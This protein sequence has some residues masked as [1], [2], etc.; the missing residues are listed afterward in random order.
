MAFGRKE[1]KAVPEITGN[2]VT[3]FAMAAQAPSAPVVTNGNGHALKVLSARECVIGVVTQ[4]QQW[5]PMDNGMKGVNLIVAGGLKIAC[6]DVDL[7]KLPKVGLFSAFKVRENKSGKF[8]LLGW[9]FVELDLD[10][11]K[12]R[13]RNEASIFQLSDKGYDFDAPEEVEILASAPGMDW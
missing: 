12:K 4:H 3:D 6:G 1:D 5:G 9:R 8:V 2:P 7:A 13:L 11:Q 10:G